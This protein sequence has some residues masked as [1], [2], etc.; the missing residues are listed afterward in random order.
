MLILIHLISETDL[1]RKI[2]HYIRFEVC[3]DVTRKNAIFWDIEPS[4]Y[5]TGDTLHLRYTDQAVSAMS[6]LR[7][8]RW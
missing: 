4:S 1:S 6:D 5:L 3:T 2:A 7:F 8:S